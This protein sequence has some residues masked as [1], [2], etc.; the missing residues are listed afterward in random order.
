[1]KSM[2][3]L[4]LCIFTFQVTHSAIQS[5]AC[6]YSGD[7]SCPT[8]SNGDTCELVCSVSTA[9]CQDIDLICADNVPCI[10]SCSRGGACQGA[11]IHCGLSTACAIICNDGGT[12]TPGNLFCGPGDCLVQC[13]GAGACQ[14]L[15][16]TLLPST[17]SFSCSG[18]SSNCNNLPVPFVSPT[19]FPTK[20][21]SQSPS[22]T[23][24]ISPTSESP[25][26]SPSKNPSQ[27]PSRSPSVSLL[28]LSL[29]SLVTWPVSNKSSLSLRSFC[30]SS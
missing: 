13:S 4:L 19:D 15:D 12:C 18:P 27:S 20:M 16:A 30:P 21:P 5:V 24:S 28:W 26:E 6:D 22:K 3:S 11:T 29:P 10:V 1:M 7:C 17:T 25:S 14:N 8:I 2:G 23:P 9:T